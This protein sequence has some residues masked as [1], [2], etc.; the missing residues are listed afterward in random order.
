MVLKRS[1]LGFARFGSTIALAVWLPNW[2]AVA[3]WL[4]VRVMAAAVCAPMR[5][6]EPLGLPGRLSGL[7]GES[8]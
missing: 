4:S 7:S 6:E 1:R 2:R 5:C 8:A 3:A